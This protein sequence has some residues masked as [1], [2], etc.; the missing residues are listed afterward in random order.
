M[1]LDHLAFQ[2]TERKATTIA[3]NTNATREKGRTNPNAEELA[4]GP[5]VKAW[6]THPRYT[7]AELVSRYG[8]NALDTRWISM[9]PRVGGGYKHWDSFALRDGEFFA[10]LDEPLACAKRSG[11]LLLYSASRLRSLDGSPLVARIL[12]NV[13]ELSY[14]IFDYDRVDAPP[15]A[16]AHRAA[17]LDLRAMAH[18]SPS[19][20]AT[21]SK[22]LRHKGVPGSEESRHELVAPTAEACLKH[23]IAEGYDPAILGALT[24]IDPAKVEFE[25][26]LPRR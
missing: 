3:A 8:P 22:I 20:G 11:V 23:L 13:G 1:K 18:R 21:E 5:L 2:E 24:V 19:D 10:M 12:P 25:C 14:A 7:D 26:H 4:V 15:P 9:A 17:A 6:A 16:L